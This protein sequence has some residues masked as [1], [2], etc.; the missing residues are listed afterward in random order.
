MKP[1][2]ERVADG[3]FEGIPYRILNEKDGEG[4]ARYTTEIWMNGKWHCAS[5]CSLLWYGPRWENEIRA[6]IQK[7]HS[8]HECR[9]IDCPKHKIK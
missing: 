5:P 8:G 3:K 4:F 1:T 6:A 2:D 9:W 7:N